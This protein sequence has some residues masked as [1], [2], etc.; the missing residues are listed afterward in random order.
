MRKWIFC[1]QMLLLPWLLWGCGKTEAAPELRTRYETLQTCEMEAV[2]SC[3]WDDEVRDYR[4]H[5]AYDRAGSSTIEV[6]EP[7]NL[8][9]VTA[10]VE[11]DSLQLAYDDAVLS[12]GTIN[13]L[14]PADCLPRLMGTLGEGWLLAESRETWG[15]IPCLRLTFDTTG[16]DGGK[17]VDTIWLGLAD[18]APVHG[19]TAVAEEI[20]FQVEFTKFDFGATI[21]EDM[22]TAPV[23]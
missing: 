10:T 14:S 17:I 5:C 15:D 4:L 8:A 9:G 6:L 18:G 20:I 1:A 7:E 21:T 11:G 2:V 22:T 16:A 12:A 3:T 23:A 13:G 19:E